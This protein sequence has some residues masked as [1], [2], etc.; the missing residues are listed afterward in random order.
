[1][2][3]SLKYLLTSTAIIFSVIL[4]ILSFI[5]WLH[6]K[7][8]YPLRRLMKLT[9]R[10]KLEQFLLL[11]VVSGF[12][13][14]GSTKGT[15]GNVN[16]ATEQSTRSVSRV[17]PVAIDSNGFFMPTNFSA[18]TNLCF[19]GIEKTSEGV[20]LGIAWPE[21][22]EFVNNVIDV[23]GNWKLSTNGW[24]HL[25]EIDISEASSN[26]VIEIDSA[27]FST[28]LMDSVAFFR[29]ASQ[30]DSDEDGIS[31]KAEEWCVGTNPTRN[32]SDGDFIDDGEE[33]DRGMNPMV[34][35]SDQ[36]GLSDMYELCVYE[37]NPL[38]VDSDGDSLPDNWEIIQGLDPLDSTGL[39]GAD[40]DPYFEGITNI[41]KY[42]MGNNAL[43][44]AT[45]PN[46]TTDYTSYGASW[47][48][49]TGDL[50]SGIEKS[51]TETVSIPKGTKAFV[52]IFLHSEEY[53]NYTGVA[54]KYNDVLSW[55]V[56][57]SGNSS[58]SGSTRVNDENGE[59]SA[60]EENY[61]YIGYWEPVVLQ[62]GGVYSAPNNTN[63]QISIS[64][65]AK[66]VSDG[67]L[68][69]TVIVG[70][71]P[72]ENIQTGWPV[73]TGFGRVADSGST[74]RKRLAENEVGYING[75][76]A[77][78]D[79]TSKFADLPEWIDVAWSATLTKERSE[80]PAS[81][82]RT[83]N[84]TLLWGDEAFDIY[85]KISD[86]IGGSIL[87]NFNIADRFNGSTSYKVRGKNPTDATARA[88]IDANVPA[89]TVD[90]A[91]KIAVHESKQGTRIYNQF[92]TGS[93][94][95]ELPNKGSGFGWG[96]AQIDNHNGNTDL[97]PFSQVWNWHENISG[98]NSKL[99][100]ALQRTNAFIGYYREAYG[101]R[102]NW[103]EPPSIMVL[104]QEVSAEMWSVLTIYNGVGGIPSQTAGSHSGFRSPLQFNP[105]TGRWIFHSN[106]TNPDYVRRVV[107][108]GMISN[109]RE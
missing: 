92:N 65:S 46:D 29:M 10:P 109:A 53:P 37:T 47:V 79:I 28:N 102:P 13:Q 96:I 85:E 8:I 34:S 94:S 90:Y 4:L 98:M 32:D 57:A 67:A 39:D 38:C 16:I 71:F 11:F 18:I 108:A 5:L 83:V 76:P 45:S 73:G 63:L 21:N 84:T 88:Y 81:D 64:I 80:R 62:S 104:G 68:P 54:S 103:I 3:D 55:N 74:I 99:Q 106:T 9:R 61:Q 19:W 25:A 105:T 87:V 42:Q 15:N 24:F 44:M 107:G 49:V 33:I 59:W 48:T 40:G 75:T 70:V 50:S 66:N 27:S 35:D 2:I 6:E 41:E 30:Q 7:H 95:K 26:A 31:D 51:H 17:T 69:S 14:Y 86:S 52:G 82:N 56:E 91:W 23:F 43:M 93:V 36:D 72:L 12:I 89:A 20:T 1:M 100:Y 97:T 101:D 60:A 78:P 77:R 22:C 58:L